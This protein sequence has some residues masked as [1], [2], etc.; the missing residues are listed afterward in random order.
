[1]TQ[2]FAHITDGND[3]SVWQADFLLFNNNSAAVTAQMIFHLDNGV[4]NLAI[5]DSGAVPGINGITIQPFGSAIYRT[6]GLAAT[7]PVVTGWVE[8]ISSLPLQGQVVLRRNT[9]PT[10]ALGNYYE[11][12]VPLATPA[13]HFTF[14]FD[15]TTYTPANARIYTA[16]AIANVTNAQAVLSC[17]AYG[18]NGS[19]LGATVQVASLPALAHTQE[20]LQFSTPIDAI[21]DQSR[22]LLDCTSTQ[23]MAILGLRAFGNNALSGLPIV[24]GN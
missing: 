19:T 21:I 20:V 1:V 10:S 16:L 12:S 8:V 11:V 2:V 17:A 13:M 5:Q 9:S 7:K 24:F 15:G 3:G 18:P 22:G 6:T 23:P 14:P 4:Q